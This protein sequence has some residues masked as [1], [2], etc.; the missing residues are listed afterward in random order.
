MYFAICN[1]PKE[2]YISIFMPKI[3]VFL[4][5]KY[6]NFQVTFVTHL[7]CN[8]NVSIV[9][10]AKVKFLSKNPILTT[11]NIFTSFSPNF[12]LTIFLVKSKLSAA[13]KSKTTTISRVFHPKRLTIFSGNQS[14]FFGQKMKIS[15]SVNVTLWKVLRNFL[16][17]PVAKRLFAYSHDDLLSVSW[18]VG[19]KATVMC[20]RRSLMDLKW[21]YP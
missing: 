5:Y 12:V 11:P 9:T 8:L 13:K 2:L 3:L 1:A 4:D 16:W 7:N 18:F 14:W 6:L 17:H 20:M 15:N 21:T 19:N 10:N